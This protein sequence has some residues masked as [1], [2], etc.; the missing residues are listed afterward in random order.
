MEGMQCQ[1]MDVWWE[2]ILGKPGH[3]CRILSQAKGLT[4]DLGDLCM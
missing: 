4:L 2:D 1:D 3:W